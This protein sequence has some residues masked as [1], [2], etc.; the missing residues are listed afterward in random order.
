MN[1]VR[2]ICIVCLLAL[3]FS[4]T[5]FT[6]AQNAPAGGLQFV[7][8]PSDGQYLALAAAKNIRNAGSQGTL[9]ALPPLPLYTLESDAIAAGKGLETAQA[10]GFQYLIESSE[11]RFI[12]TAEIQIDG[13]CRSRMNGLGTGRLGLDTRQALSL[14]EANDQ[15][16]AGRYEV[17]MIYAS[18][19]YGGLSRLPLVAVWLKSLRKGEDLIYPLQ[20][21][22]I[23]THALDTGTAF[24]KRVRPRLANVQW[25]SDYD[26]HAYF[27]DRFL[28]SP[29]NG[30]SRVM[31]DPMALQDSMRLRITS[32]DTYELESL[33]LIGIGKHPAPVGF[34]GRRH[35]TVS[36]NRETRA[37][38]AFEEKAVAELKAGEDVASETG[39]TGR[40]VVG[41][42]R[43]REDCLKCHGGNPGD[44]LGALSYR[45]IP[46]GPVNSV[47]ALTIRSR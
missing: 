46:A 32:R 27:V 37:L 25:S 36:M 24:L 22:G 26:L 29:G 34:L 8:G 11:A 18:V 39:R 33:D 45:L 42:L 44:V 14:L 40:V 12:G 20:A 35:Q 7:A 5:V 47:V 17:R 4:W 41:A 9:H 15:V 6:G 21:A 23:P 10:C 30:I 28:E 16:K 38:T 3:T 43:A 2:S 1:P 31:Q 13:D 19:N